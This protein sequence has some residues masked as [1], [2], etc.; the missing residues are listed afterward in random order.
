MR[1]QGVMSKFTP[2]LILIPCKCERKTRAALVVGVND[3]TDVCECGKVIHVIVDYDGH[4]MATIRKGDI[5]K[6]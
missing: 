1:W 5:I 6:A 4:G 3:I 2:P